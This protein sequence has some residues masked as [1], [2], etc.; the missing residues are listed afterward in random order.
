MN[1]IKQLRYERKWSQGTLASMVKTSPQ[2]IQ[3]IE[4]GAQAAR[5]P[6]A[7]DICK[8]FNEP[9]EKVFPGVTKALAEFAGT[10]EAHLSAADQKY[11]AIRKLGVEPDPN[12]YNLKVLLQGHNEYLL[13]KNIPAAE[14]NRFFRLI[15]Q[16]ADND[17]SSFVVFESDEFYM[18]VNRRSLIHCHSETDLSDDILDLA[19]REEEYILENDVE[20][21]AEFY[22][23]GNPKPFH[24]EIAPEDS[25]D[26]DWHYLSN[27]FMDLDAGIPIDQIIH[28][29]DI[30]GE[31]HFIKAEAISF[32]KVPHR[33]LESDLT[34]S[35]NFWIDFQY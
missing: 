12:F 21:C 27:A 2:L 7:M 1:M 4:S 8:A 33:M 14:V 15:C 24:I 34:E 17:T 28:I 32:L 19:A 31:R 5:L 35:E 13:L 6:L 11:D 29:Q 30:N 18:A 23:T 3:R 9:I 10:H 26:E 20:N 16:E 25:S 22:F